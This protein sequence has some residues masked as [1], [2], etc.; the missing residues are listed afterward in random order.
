MKKLEHVAFG[1][2]AEKIVEILERD[3]GLV[4]TGVLTLDEVNAINEDLNKVGFNVMDELSNTDLDAEGYGGKTA[5]LTHCL[6][7]SKTLRERYL[8]SEILA[9][10]LAATIPGPKGTYGMYA[11]HGIEICPGEKHQQLHRDACTMMEI[12]GTAGPSGKNFMI[13]FLLALTE[14]T[15]EMGAT[16]VI[17]GS[18]LWP[19][20]DVEGTQEQTVAATMNPGDMVMINGKVIHGGGANNTVDR[21]RRV[22]STTFMPAIMRGEEAWPHVLTAEEVRT[23]P[24]RVQGYIGFR[25][26]SFTGEQPGFMWR[27]HGKPLEEYL[28]L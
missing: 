13:N 20:F 26:I 24:P 14:V 21:K 22:I 5:R 19:D 8:D 16:R 18:H 10:Y 28:D 17:P 4:L 23:Y 12:F 11:S 1:S 15:E 2:P 7:Y 9:D 6:K 3:G 27:A 25:S